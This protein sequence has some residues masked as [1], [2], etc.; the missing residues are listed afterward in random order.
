MAENLHR[1]DIF[2]LPS[3]Y[4]GISL[5]IIEAMGTGLPIVAS[6]VG[7]M[8]NMITDGADG[9]LC[10]PTA[11]SVAEKL[12]KLIENQELRIRLGQKAVVSAERF[13]ASS[14]LKGYL[15]IY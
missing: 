5:A 4:E 12:E 1:S 11:Q 9:L 8:P 15:D 2:V 3:L 14:M 13:S 6:D 10:E 7:G